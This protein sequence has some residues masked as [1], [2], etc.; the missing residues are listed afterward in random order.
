MEI[1]E[2]RPIWLQLVDEF[3]RRVAVGEWPTGSKIPSV[4]ELA[5]E[6]GVNPN[7]VQRAL[8][9]TDRLGL[10]VP[11]RTSGRFVTEDGAVVTRVRSELA[12]TTIDGFIAVVAGLGMDLAEAL[13][14]L[15]AR[16]PSAT[17]EPP[18]VHNKQKGKR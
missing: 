4:R 2:S 6:V 13:T 12:E 5:L 3:R 11:V 10:T 16:W 17:D 7:T 1:D 9:E 8:S 15:S 18:A 14:S